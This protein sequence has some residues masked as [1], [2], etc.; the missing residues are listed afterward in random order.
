SCTGLRLNEEFVDPKVDL[1]FDDEY[2]SGLFVFGGELD[3][4]TS[5]AFTGGNVADDLQCDLLRQLLPVCA[6]EVFT[7]ELLGGYGHCDNAVVVVVL[8]FLGGVEHKDG[9]VVFD[10][11]G[12]TF[13]QCGFG[14]TFPT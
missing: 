10:T 8:G 13:V 4:A 9:L 7:A 11:L 12:A 3:G 14:G 6:C 1:A 2:G 5:N